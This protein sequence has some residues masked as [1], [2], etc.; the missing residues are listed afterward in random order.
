MIF[1][2]FIKYFFTWI[3]HILHNFSSDYI[4]ANVDLSPET[5]C[6]RCQHSGLRS[7]RWRFA[8]PIFREGFDWC[9]C[10]KVKPG[11]LTFYRWS[12]KDLSLAFG[13]QSK[14]I[15]VIG[16]HLAAQSGWRQAAK[17]NNPWKI[18]WT[19]VKNQ[20]S[21]NITGHVTYNESNMLLFAKLFVESV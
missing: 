12:P 15:R 2:I 3:I 8:V 1:I 14:C 6:E 18:I 4:I 10:W 16:N 20:A 9:F 7:N 5:F 19:W 13:V 17:E 11:Q 21:K